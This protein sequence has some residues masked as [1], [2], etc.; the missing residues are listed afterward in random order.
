MKKLTALMI[1]LMLALA[2]VPAAALAATAPVG[3]TEKVTVDGREVD[4][5]DAITLTGGGWVSLSVDGKTLTLNNAHI[6]K[7]ADTGMVSYNKALTINLVGSST[8]KYDGAAANA[9]GVMIG[10]DLS[11]KGS[12]SL[13]VEMMNKNSLGNTEGIWTGGKLS[14]ADAKVY[15]SGVGGN[16][17]G[18]S[19]MDSICVNSANITSAVTAYGESEDSIANGIVAGGDFSADGAHIYVAVLCTNGS[20]RGLDAANMNL[21]R[22]YVGGSANANSG[23]AYVL[24][25]SESLNIKVACRIDIDALAGEGTAAGVYCNG[26][27]TVKDSRIDIDS[28]TTCFDNCEQ[29]CGSFGMLLHYADIINSKIKINAGRNCQCTVGTVGGVSADYLGVDGTALTVNVSSTVYV[30]GNAGMELKQLVIEGSSNVRVNG[31][32]NCDGVLLDYGRSAFRI[33]DG[34]LYINVGRLGLAGVNCDMLF[35]GGS[36]DINAGI[37]AVV[38]ANDGYEPSFAFAKKMGIANSGVTFATDLDGCFA[39][40]KAGSPLS[41]Q[42][43]DGAITSVSGAAGSI[44]IAKGYTNAPVM[45][46]VT[47]TTMQ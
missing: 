9:F 29:Y 28:K 30:Q 13:K 15:V 23:E 14:I 18:I 34:R 37:A 25:A 24:S 36:C 38:G 16:I 1:A 4:P 11:I 2:L 35:N 43:I 26:T 22:T 32:S 12:G 47:I 44:K 10:G 41:V 19:A 17:D 39:S 42:V 21:K 31:D 6:T 7:F 5:G 46:K 33:D 40:V 45:P 8:V 27:A 3:G 20:A